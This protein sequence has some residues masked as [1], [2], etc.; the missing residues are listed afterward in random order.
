MRFRRFI[1]SSLALLGLAAGMATSASAEAQS[2]IPLMR[3]NPS[4]AGDRFFGVDSPYV[5]GGFIPHAALIADYAH[6][7][8][9]LRQDGETVGAVVANQLLLHLNATVPLFHRLSLNLDLPFAAYQDG[10]KPSVGGF[11]VASPA[12]VSLGDLRAGLRFR[13]YGEYHDPFQLGIGG[14]VHFPTGPAAGNAEYVSDGNVRGTPQVTVG[15]LIDRFVYAGS[16]GVD[17]RAEQ[18]FPSTQNVPAGLNVV[19]V[20]QSSMLNIGFAAAAR[21]GE[22][23]Q[24]QVGPEV[25]FQMDLRSPDS[26]NINAEALVGAKYRFARDFE[27]GVAVGP[28]LSRGIGTPDVRALASF[29]YT[30]EVPKPVVDRDKDGILDNVD[31]C[32][33]V[34]GVASEDP[35]KNGYPPPPDTDKDGILDEADACKDVAGLPDPDPKKNGCPPPPDTDK[36]GIIDELDACKDLAGV[37]DADAKKNGCPPDK[38]GDGI[39]DADD[40]CIDIPGVKSDDKAKNGCPPDTDADSFRDDQDACPKEKGVDDPDPTKRGCPK[41][42]RVTETEVVILQQVQ[43]DT[44]KATIRKESDALLDEV[45]AVL[46]DHPEFSKVEVQGHTDNTSGKAY[47]QKLSEDRAKAV[48]KALEARKIDGSRLIAKGFGMDKPVVENK[49]ADCRQRNRRVQF[50]I[51]EK[52]GKAMPAKAEEKPQ[53]CV[54]PKKQPKADK[55]AA[56]APAP[57]PAAPAPAPKPA[58][59]A[60]A[61]KPAAPAPAPKPATPAPKPP[62]APVKP[63]PKK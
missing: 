18:D 42:V 23:R 2:G 50:V 13:I 35:A 26:R 59:P 20:S 57:K 36:D 6:N 9:V 47:N 19:P 8:L 40:A 44:A 4:S 46:R 21:L 30:P 39:Y 12:A 52:D 58:A 22:E 31:A 61:P 15:G 56:P 60:P 62:A 48:V 49:S 33:D 1:C 7:P 10:E 5:P 43:F 17:I 41:M 38:D 24:I 14:Y 3:F 34:P 27:A 53:E 37:P 54:D 11:N 32:I 25:T 29:A 16:V 45:A 51:V 28:G 55:P 63:A